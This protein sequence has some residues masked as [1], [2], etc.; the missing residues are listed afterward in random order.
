MN[1]VEVDKKK[2]SY[3]VFLILMIATLVGTVSALT[4]G[5]VVTGLTVYGFKSAKKMLNNYNQPAPQVSQPAGNK[6]A[7]KTDRI[8]LGERNDGCYYTIIRMVDGSGFPKDD[9]EFVVLKKKGTTPT[10]KYYAYSPEAGQMNPYL[11]NQG[12]YTD[13][14]SDL[15]DIVMVADNPEIFQNKTNLEFKIVDLDN[16]II[17]TPDDYQ[18][19][20]DD[21]L[22]DA[23]GGILAYIVV[24]LASILGAI[25]AGIQF[26]ITLLV[27]VAFIVFLILFLV[28]LSK[29]K[30]ESLIAE[31]RD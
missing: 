21:A 8:D 5:A 28:F 7:F 9:G 1:N 25:L 20:R 2:I 14:F 24:L 3:I 30:K 26:L 11:I 29:A 27:F 19:E 17:K 16:D 6:V 4:S 13:D 15:I 31:P 22:F 10:V 12:L 23:F 18:K